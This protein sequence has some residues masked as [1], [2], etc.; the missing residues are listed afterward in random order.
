MAEKN[1]AGT[2][3]HH[4]LVT[5]GGSG[6][7]QAVAVELAQEGVLVY[8]L[9]RDETKLARTK[10]LVEAQGGQAAILAGDLQDDEFVAEVAA[11]LTAAG[12]GLDVLVHAAGMFSM[13]SLAQ[14]SMADFDAIYRTNVRAPYFLTQVCLPLLERVRGLVVFINSTAGLQ[15]GPN[16]GAYSM[17]KAAL[18]F[19]AD[20]LRAEVNVRGIRVLSVFPGRTASPLQEEICR[21]EGREY[22]PEALMQPGDVAALVGQALQ[23]PRTAEVTDIMMR[24]MQKL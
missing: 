3:L 23:L 7:G 1:S 15:A 4:V 14:S 13:G 9:G 10:R 20:S 21:L 19:L 5:G 12:A 8:L 2:G 6:I 18:K 24:P 17:S 11:K 16:W 22:R